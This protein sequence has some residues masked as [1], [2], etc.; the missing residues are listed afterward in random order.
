MKLFRIVLIFL[1]L[2][3]SMGLVS[4]QDDL[5]DTMQA[6]IIMA[7]EVGSFEELEN[8][9][10]NANGTLEITKDYK[11]DNYSDGIRIEKDNLVINGN[12]HAIDGNGQNIFCI[13][14]SN[15]TINNLVF[16][17]AYYDFGGALIQLAAICF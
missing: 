2:I 14:G 10:I 8:A 16:K 11:N 13:K 4:A 3:M 15:I 6:D 12:N 5:N 7:D 1:F 17:N 9:I